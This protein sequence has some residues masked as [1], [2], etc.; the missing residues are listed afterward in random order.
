MSETIADSEV[1]MELAYL[2]KQL[3]PAIQKVT[4]QRVIDIYLSDEN[5]LLTKLRLRQKGG[6]YEMTKKIVLDPADL[7]VQQEFNIPLTAEEFEKLKVV[8]GREVSK[9][10]YVMNIGGHQAEIDIFLGALAGF[11]IV[12]FEF[13]APEDKVAFKP[14]K[15][16]GAEVTQ[17]DFIAGAYL[18][19]KA[20]DDIAAELDRFNYAP[21]RIET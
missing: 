11:A 16:C 2:P 1:E 3:P 19:G 17:E 12:E 6:K 13:T 5:D 9:D 10:R 21:I 14:P 20:Y 7:S 8:G 15:F 4:P 18:A